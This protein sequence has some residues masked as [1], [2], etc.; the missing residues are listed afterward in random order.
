M[1]EEEDIRK[2]M[3]ACSELPKCSVLE[4]ET[5]VFQSPV[6]ISVSTV[7]SLNRNWYLQALPARQRF[8]RVVYPQLNPNTLR[9]FQAFI[10]KVL[11]DT[12]N[13]LHLAQV[14]WN[15]NEKN[16]A[17]QLSHLIDYFITWHNANASELAE[18]EAL[19][20]W[21]KQIPKSEFLGSIRGLGPR[22]YEQLL[23][24]LERTNAIKLDRHIKSYVR[25]VLRRSVSE[26]DT[27]AALREVARRIDISAT[28]LDARIWDYM[29]SRGGGETGTER[30]CRRA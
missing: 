5:H 12:G 2:L 20:R 22:A 23:W 21:A 1:L 19:Q 18:L 11:D 4:E 28:A 7:L 13:W 10:R 3:Q 9:E 30:A 17:E 29:R 14:L 6:L 16:K 15:T 27:L 26:E 24:Y 25:T 8:E